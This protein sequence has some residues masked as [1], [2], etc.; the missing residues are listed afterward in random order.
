MEKLELDAIN[1]LHQLGGYEHVD[2]KEG[3]P[4]ILLPAILLANFR[5]DTGNVEEK[6]TIQLPNGDFYVV[7]KPSLTGKVELAQTED[8]LYV[9][10]IEIPFILPKEKLFH[11]ASISPDRNYSPR[12]LG[13]NFEIVTP[14]ENIFILRDY[15][16]I[17]N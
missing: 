5:L 14:Q 10:S 1:A 7:N 4:A 16:R 11:L 2:S 13:R 8:R 12:I 17:S 9:S 3:L 6:A 15:E